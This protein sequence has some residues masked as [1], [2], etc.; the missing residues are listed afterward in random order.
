MLVLTGCGTP[1]I[2]RFPADDQSAKLRYVTTA[3]L[4]DFTYLRRVD[5]SMCPSSAQSMLIATTG[6]LEQSQIAM[7]GSSDVAQALVREFNIPASAPLTFYVAAS[8]YPTYS[9]DNAGVFQP[10]PG[11]QYELRHIVE[12]VTFVCI[13]E[14][15]ELQ[16]G[17]DGQV[18]RRREP[19]AHYFHP[20]KKMQDYCQ[21]APRAN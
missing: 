1:E 20:P 13:V 16:Q 5:R 21:E 10:M 6:T 14:I 19:S 3:A 11:R 7:I 8:R 15:D 18:M 17:D 2:V 4:S 12:P 9:C